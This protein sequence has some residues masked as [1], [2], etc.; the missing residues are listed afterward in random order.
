MA[1]S[2]SLW[3][4]IGVAIIALG[5]A[6]RLNPMLAVI[7]ATITTAFAA[8]FDIEQV[9]ATIG[10]GFLRTRN[11]P[12]IIFMPLAV[13]GLLERHG[14]R[15]QAQNF[16][17]GIKAATA[18][19]LLIVYLAIRQLTAAMGLTSL[20]GHPQMVR[21]LIA[22]MAEGAAENR[23]GSLPDHIRHKLRAYAAAADNVG[24]FFGEDIFVAFG[25][26]V[27]MTTFLQEAGITVAPLHMALWGIPTAIT[28]FTI[29]AWRTYLLDRELTKELGQPPAKS[30]DDF[31]T[32]NATGE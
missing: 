29:H 30:E 14:L 2:V 15:Q 27:L 25:A 6:F 20:G 28:A 24:L 3:P 18:G 11:L 19:R 21:P 7:V 22:P 12:L 31:S 23:Y 10:S 9:L 16:I 13:I 17:R 5:F 4:L 26:I 32:Q 1:D 8:G